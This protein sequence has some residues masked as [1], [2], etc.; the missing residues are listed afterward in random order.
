MS[1]E[2]AETVLHGYFDNELDAAGA[3]EFER[4]LDGCA[5]CADALEGLKKLRATMSG[6]QFMSESQ[7][8]TLRKRSSCRS[9]RSNQWRMIAHTPLA[10]PGNGWPLAATILLLAPTAGSCFV[11]RGGDKRCAC[12]TAEVVDAHLRSLQPGHLTDVLSTD[13]HTVKPWF[14][15]K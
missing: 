11:R 4:Q 14:D 6:A 12:W 1:C 7:P 10:T 13:Q 15:G 2:R 3:D 8:E 5:E 9:A